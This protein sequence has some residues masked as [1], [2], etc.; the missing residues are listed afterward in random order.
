MDPEKAKIIVIKSSK[1]GIKGDTRSNLTFQTKSDEQ[2]VSSDVDTAEA[3]R[4]L[5][6]SDELKG[7]SGAMKSQLANGMNVI[8]LPVHSMPIIS[9]RLVFA[10]AGT[11]STPEN[12]KLAGAAADFLNLP[13]DAEAFA[14]TG[15]EVGCGAETDNAVCES[16]GLSIYL[17]VMLKGLERLVTAGEYRQERIES[18]QKREKTHFESKLAQ[19][20]TEYR[21]QLYNALYGAAHP[22]TVTGLDTPEAAGK[23]HRDALDAFRHA[24][25]TAG[26]ATLI[27]VGDFDPAQAAATAKSVFGGWAKGGANKAID[28]K[29]Q[30]P[31]GQTYV[32]VVGKEG[33]QMQVSMAYPSVPGVDGQEA[34]RRVLVEMMNIRVG[35]V[36]FRLGST[37]GV[38]AGRLTHTGTGAYVI[39]GGGVDAERTGES[40]KAMRDGI[41]MLRKGE[42]FDDDFVRA[43]RDVIKRLL[44]ESTVTSELADRLALASEYGLPPTYYNT[45]LQ[46]VAAVS[47]AQIHSLIAQELDPSHEIIVVMGDRPHLEKAFADAGLKDVKIIEPDYK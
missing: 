24:H 17:D 31:T 19:Q 14:R 1:E 40:I 26:N 28:A 41:D 9:A 15:V 23:V 39:G 11:S 47:T 35:D 32:G 6:V 38:Y 36:R 30:K 18:W 5:K 8:L 2:M 45:L 3:H 34:A 16:G 21:R 44:G 10:N 29:A 42:H 12:P 25:Y 7:I 27:V 13:M 37:Y 46:Q 4:L 43:R 20:Q 22:Y 33:P